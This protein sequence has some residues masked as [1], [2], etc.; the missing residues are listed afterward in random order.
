MRLKALDQINIS[1]IKAETIRPKEEVEVS[2]ELG[3]LLLERHPLV[4]KRAKADAAPLVRVPA[5]AEKPPANK[6]DAR[7]KTKAAPAA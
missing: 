1:A 5:K 2:E 3:R 7:R 6:S 4:F